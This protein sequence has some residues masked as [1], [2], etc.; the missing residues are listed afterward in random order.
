MTKGA[1]PEGDAFL[2]RWNALD[3]RDRLRIRRLVRLGRAMDDRTDAELAVA[4]ARFQAS[5]PWGRMFWVWFV[6]G[7]MLSLAAA[8]AIHPVL[9]GVVLALATQALFAR[10]NLRRAEAVNAPL[11]G[12]PSPLRRL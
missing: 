9:I 10:R 5:R 2:E 8:G 12:Q 1:I 6:P 4:Y 3:R 11:L 7:L